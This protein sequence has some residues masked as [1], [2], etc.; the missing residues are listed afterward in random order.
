ME[1]YTQ[2]FYYTLDWIAHWF[3]SI[4]LDSRFLSKYDLIVQVHMFLLD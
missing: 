1:V 3:D 4:K 2:Y